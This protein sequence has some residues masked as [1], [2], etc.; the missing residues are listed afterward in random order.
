MATISGEVRDENNDLLADCV[1]R[2]YRRDTGALLVTGL[3]GDGSEEQAGDAD[4]ASVSLLL[5]CDESDGSTTITDSGPAARTVTVAGNAHIGVDQSKFSGASAAFD[6]TGDYLTSASNAAFNLNDGN[7]TVEGWMYM[8]SATNG[9]AMCSRRTIGSAGW[10]MEANALRGYING[11]FS[12]SQITWTRPST[13]AWHHYAFVKNSTTIT[14][15][16]DGTSVGSKTSVT[17]IQDQ[18]E[19]LRLGVA[20]NNAENALNGYLDEFRFTKGVARYTENFTA[21]TAVFPE[22]TIPAKPLGEY[23][24]TTAYTDEVQVIAL[25]PAGGTTFNDMIL[26]TTPV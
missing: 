15:Y 26:R 13:G 18:A 5:H 9:P 23:S 1:V 20:S 21:P 3:T 11:S 16:V 12:D 6:G 25:D 2:A 8:T 17:S 7:W 14:V 22:D 24:L 4:Y 19:P 10:S